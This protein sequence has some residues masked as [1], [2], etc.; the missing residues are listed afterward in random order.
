VFVVLRG[1]VLEKVG[2]IDDIQFQAVY[3][4]GEIAG[5]QFMK[6]EN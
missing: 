5:L 2:E 1:T 4:E 3:K 6:P